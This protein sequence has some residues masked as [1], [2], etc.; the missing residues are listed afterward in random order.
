MTGSNHDTPRKK[1]LTFPKGCFAN[2]KKRDRWKEEA[3][4]FFFISPLL[5][6]KS[7]SIAQDWIKAWIKITSPPL[8]L[9]KKGKVFTQPRGS[10]LHSPHQKW[11]LSPPLSLPPSLKHSS[12][13]V[14]FISPCLCCV[15][16]LPPN[17]GGKSRG[18]LEQTREAKKEKEEQEERKKR[19]KEGNPALEPRQISNMPG[20]ARE[21]NSPL[22]LTPLSTF[23]FPKSL[24]FPFPFFPLLFFFFCC[25]SPFQ[26]NEK[27]T[28]PAKKKKRK[29]KASQGSCQEVE[30]KKAY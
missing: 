27:I 7:L 18:Q 10:L 23:F 11:F 13:L 28:T 8:L 4:I 25:V 9:A 19:K 21:I 12:F 17:K 20:W 5:Q 26:V 14:F 24:S 30:P 3:H 29:E 6:P 22:S 1:E 16:Y 2:Q 15:F